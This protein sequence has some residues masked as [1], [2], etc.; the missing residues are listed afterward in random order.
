[1]LQTY[2]NVLSKHT[3]VNR[4]ISA[5]GFARC[6]RCRDDD[7][8][9]QGVPIVVRWPIPVEFSS[10]ILKKA[11][12]GLCVLWQ[13]MANATITPVP[14]IA[15]SQWEEVDTEDGIKVSTRTVPGSDLIAVKGEAVLPFERGQVFTL[16]IDHTLRHLWV[17]RLEAIKRLKEYNGH[18]DAVAHYEVDLPWP[19]AD[20]DFVVRT[21]ISYDADSGI[22]SSNTH[23]VTGYLPEQDGYVRAFSHNSTVTLAQLPDGG[24]AISVEARVDP[25]GSIPTWLIN[26]M[27]TRWAYLT[28]SSLSDALATHKLAVDPVYFSL[29][30]QQT[31]AANP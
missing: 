15:A 23:S 17:D 5:W 27:Q 14:A 19:V 11:L 16:M 8:A 13:G 2:G 31:A 12:L 6:S 22:I 1:M 7:P 9:Q 20:R 26:Y 4:R 18:L 21:V 28:L 29:T 25:R 3:L 24:T 10:P 30:G